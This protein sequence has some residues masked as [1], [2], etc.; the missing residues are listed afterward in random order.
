M[1]WRVISND[2][3]HDC[4][5]FQDPSVLYFSTHRCVCMYVTP[6]SAPAYHPARYHVVVESRCNLKP[7][8]AAMPT[9]SFHASFNESRYD[10]GRFYPGTKY[11]HYTSAG[12]GEGE[13]F[14]VNVPWP[15]LHLTPNR[16]FFTVFCATCRLPCG[17]FVYHLN[18]LGCECHVGYIQ[19]F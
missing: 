12:S 8:L 14:S 17:C 19:E 9:L 7:S 15:R 6:S 16:F 1:H 11:G 13:G 10:G 18:R 2:E 5:F 4:L 3:S